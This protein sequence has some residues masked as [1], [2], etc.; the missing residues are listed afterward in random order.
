VPPPTLDEVLAALPQMRLVASLDERNPDPEVVSLLR[1]SVED[2]VAL[3]GA[4][5]LHLNWGEED[6][7]LA[8]E[9]EAPE[10]A[11]PSYAYTTEEAAATEGED[12][13]PLAAAL[14]KAMK[15]RGE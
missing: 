9:P 7:E 5:N 13:N 8:E 6:E 3:A 10:E 14:R 2:I 12:D 15:D 1:F 4:E 11:R